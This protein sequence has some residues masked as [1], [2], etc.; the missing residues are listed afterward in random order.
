MDILPTVRRP[1]APRSKKLSASLQN[2]SPLGARKRRPSSR[3]QDPQRRSWNFELGELGRQ[4]LAQM[5]YRP[6]N[7]ELSTARRASGRH[8]RQSVA[9]FRRTKV[10]KAYRQGK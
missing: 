2:F 5:V 9:F 4:V 6:R 7:R 1:S 3:G 10:R 8:T